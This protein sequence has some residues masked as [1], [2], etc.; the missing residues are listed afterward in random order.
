MTHLFESNYLDRKISELDDRLSHTNKSDKEAITLLSMFVMINYWSGTIT[1]FTEDSPNVLE[2]CYQLANTMRQPHDTDSVPLD[3]ARDGLMTQAKALVQELK[4]KDPKTTNS[5][6]YYFDSF[7]KNIPETNLP[8]AEN[9]LDSNELLQSLAF[10][11]A[12]DMMN[13]SH[14]AL[15]SGTHALDEAVRLSLVNLMSMFEEGQ[16]NGRI[17]TYQ[18]KH[19]ELLFLKNL[20]NLLESKIEISNT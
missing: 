2:D 10:F 7:Y 8:S 13:E 5:L 15:S 4:P 6:E 17:P 11:L 18:M 20:T 14:A 19:R 3:D 12:L 16:K 9:T 1:G